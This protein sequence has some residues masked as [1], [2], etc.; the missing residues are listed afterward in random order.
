ML[1]SKCNS[2]FDFQWYL[3]KQW[4]LMRKWFALIIG[5]S[6]VHTASHAGLLMHVSILVPHTSVHRQLQQGILHA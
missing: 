3:E 2:M 4:E 6:A 1:W 5:N